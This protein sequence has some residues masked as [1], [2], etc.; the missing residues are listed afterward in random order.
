MALNQIKDL[1]RMKL[2]VTADTGK[3]DEV[4][5]NDKVS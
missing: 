1:W 5:F 2:L 3:A 4:V